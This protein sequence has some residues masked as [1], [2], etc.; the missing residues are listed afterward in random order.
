M[1]STF[2]PRHEPGS[3][4]ERM[5]IAKSVRRTPSAEIGGVLSVPGVVKSPVVSNTNASH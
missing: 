4:L 3:F 2:R 1:P 5:G